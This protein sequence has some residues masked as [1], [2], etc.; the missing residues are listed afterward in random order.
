MLVG[1]SGVG[2]LPFGAVVELM[3]VVLF[4][5]PIDELMLLVATEKRRRCL[6]NV[7]LPKQLPIR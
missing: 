3:V 6:G 7:L 5:C 4:C 1:K 2:W